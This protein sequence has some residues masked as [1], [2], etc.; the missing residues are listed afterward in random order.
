MSTKV[1]VHLRSKER[2]DSAKQRSHNGSSSEGCSC[3]PDVHVDDVV[4]P[5]PYKSKSN[6]TCHKTYR[7]TKR[8]RMAVPSRTI[9][10]NGLTQCTSGPLVHA[11]QNME[12]TSEQEQMTE[13][14]SLFS[15]LTG[16]GAISATCFRYLGSMTVMKLLISSY[17]MREWMAH[18]IVQIAPPPKIAR[19]TS[20]F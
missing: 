9:A 13:S 7:L 5:V 18:N 3:R 12:T 8:P 17:Q 19:K 1:L 6:S 2:E 20:P 14:S 11:N 15:G 16:F 10:N 4:G